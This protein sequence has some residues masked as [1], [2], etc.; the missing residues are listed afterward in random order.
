MRGPQHYA[1]TAHLLARIQRRERL[2]TAWKTWAG[3]AAF[4]AFLVGASP[5][6]EGATWGLGLALVAGL[7]AWGSWA[8]GPWR[9][10]AWRLRRGWPV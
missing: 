6:V 1:R 9:G 2:R 8:E 4:G 10:T 3:V 7:A 5:E